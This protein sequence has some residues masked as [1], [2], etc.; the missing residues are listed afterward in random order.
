MIKTCKNCPEIF[1][2]FG[3]GRNRKFCDKCKVIIHKEQK[4]K[5]YTKLSRQKWWIDERKNNYKIKVFFKKQS[6]ILTNSPYLI[7]RK[8][9]ELTV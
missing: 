4:L 5:S 2:C 8:R 7:E 6:N 3:N 1:E 9:I